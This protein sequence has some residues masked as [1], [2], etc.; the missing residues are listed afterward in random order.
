MHIVSERTI[1]LICLLGL[2]ACDVDPREVYVPLTEPEV[3]LVVRTSA[4]EVSIGE[5]VV[6]YAERWSRGEWKLVEKKDLAKEQCWLR[7]PPENHEK[8]I[9]DR[10]RWEAFP[11]KG[12]RFNTNFRADHT[13]EVIF[14][15][16]GTFILDSSFK[17]W[18]RSEKVAKGDTIRILVRNGNGRAKASH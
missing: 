16:P 4:T 5:P 15:E 3:E 2:S 13:R 6:L 14:D 11:S 18:C 9:S 10:L 17:I 7:H 8:E 1:V 12:V